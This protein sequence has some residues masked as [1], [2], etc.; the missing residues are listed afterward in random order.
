M[1]HIILLDVLRL[2]LYWNRQQV[3]MTGNVVDRTRSD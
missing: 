1:T 2:T 3:S